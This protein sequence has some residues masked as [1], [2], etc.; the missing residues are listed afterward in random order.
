MAV[1]SEET[2]RD[3]V[4][5]IVREV[6]PERVYLFGSYA[7]GEAREDSDVD[8]LVVEHEPFGAERSR[9]RE[10]ARL[11]RLLAGFGVPK[12]ILVYSSEEVERWRRSRSH[13]I[14]HALQEGK[15]LHERPGSGARSA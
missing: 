11:W 6:D 5:S 8:I 2:V 12:D 15:L 9:R 1:V 4:D 13:V 10:M 7:R 3:M 14:G